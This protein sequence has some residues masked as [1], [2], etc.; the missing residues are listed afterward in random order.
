MSHW[1]LEWR[2]ERNRKQQTHNIY[3]YVYKNASLSQ[4]DAMILWLY[5]KFS[6]SSFYFH[7]Y[8]Q[9]N[10]NRSSYRF[11]NVFHGTHL[12]SMEIRI[13]KYFILAVEEWNE[14]ENWGDW[15][16][17]YGRKRI[18]R[19]LKNLMAFFELIKNTF[20]FMRTKIISM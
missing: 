6:Y 4:L 17:N 13:Y 19:E 12:F 10:D 18:F 9:P 5:R 1:F 2:K 7:L 14:R 3:D 20:E 15:V 11:R 16:I 8:P